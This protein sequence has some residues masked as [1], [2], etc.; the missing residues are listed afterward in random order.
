[1]IILQMKNKCQI[2]SGFMASY[3]CEIARIRKLSRNI[4]PKLH[5][6]DISLLRRNQFYFETPF[7]K[8]TWT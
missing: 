6:A 3:S 1:M 2:L 7:S 5:Q 8:N 4:F